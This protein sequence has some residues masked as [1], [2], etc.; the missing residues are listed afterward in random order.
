MLQFACLENEMEYK[1]VLLNKKKSSRRNDKL[2]RR[3]FAALLVCSMSLTVVSAPLIALADNFDSEIEQKEKEINELKDKQ[4]AL[5]A[6]IDQ[7]EGEVTTINNK[8]EK[9]L[10]KQA[11]LMKQTEKLQEE[12]A[13]LNV[14]IER[15]E[16][17]IRNQARDVQVNGSDTSVIGAILNA[18][19]FS[20]AIGR[21]Q[22]VSRIVNANNELVSQQ[23]ADQQAVETKKSETEAKIAKIQENQVSLEAQKGELQKKQAN[24]DVLKADLALEQSTKESEKATIQKRK[25]KAEAEAAR[26]AEEE[27]LAEEAR[28]QAQTNSS[29]QTQNS[30]TSSSGS[31]SS[32]STTN[33]GSSSNSSTNQ[34][35]SNSS[36]DVTQSPSPVVPGPSGSAS[37]VIAEAYKYIGVPYVWGGKDPS[38]F[39]C[40]GFTSYVY[41]KAAGREIG[42]WTVPQESAGVRISV[43]DAQPGDLYFWGSPGSTHHVAIALGGGSYIHAPQ[44]GQTVTVSSVSAYAPSFAV[45]M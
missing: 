11:E 19:S 2:K 5:Q 43:A 29:N 37:A 45:R 4:A 27:R 28:N 39:D 36:E 8:A 21:I 23:K 22:A 15:R 33:S 34:S 10:A 6:Q 42:G 31:S 1:N 24:L 44:P 3:I 13:D 30:T 12:I 18:T 9:L 17:A 38:G 41:R 26:I 14:R 32:N 7:V 35:D 16:E 40:S 20:D 25:E